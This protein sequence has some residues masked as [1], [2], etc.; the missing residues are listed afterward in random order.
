MARGDL[1]VLPVESCIDILNAL[2]SPASRFLSAR[3]VKTILNVRTGIQG[4]DELD[5]FSKAAEAMIDTLYAKPQGI[6]PEIWRTFFNTRRVIMTCNRDSFASILQTVRSL[7]STVQVLALQQSY[8]DLMCNRITSEQSSQ[9]AAA[10][11]ASQTAR[12]GDLLC[13]GGL[14]DLDLGLARITSDDADELL[15]ALKLLQKAELRVDLAHGSPW[16]PRP[17][18]SLKSF[19]VNLGCVTPGAA[20]PAAPAAPAANPV[21]D[22]GPLCDAAHSLGSISL[23]SNCSATIINAHQLAQLKSLRSLTCTYARL[24]EGAWQLLQSLPQLEYAEVR[25]MDVSITRDS[26]ML[27]RLATLKANITSVAVSAGMAAQGGLAR[28]LPSLQRLELDDLP[29]DVLEALHGSDVQ[30]LKC[31]ISAEQVA[32][33][34]EQ[35]LPEALPELRSIDCILDVNDAADALLAAAAG[36][37]HLE[38]LSVEEGARSEAYFGFEA[39]ELL[40]SGRCKKLR[41]AVLSG[42][43]ASLSG[44]MLLTTSSKQVL[45]ELRCVDVTARVLDGEDRRWFRLESMAAQQREMQQ[46]AEQG[47]AR[48]CGKRPM[49]VYDEFVAAVDSY[50][51]CNALLAAFLEGQEPEELFCAERQTEGECPG[52]MMSWMHLGLERQLGLIAGS[53]MHEQVVAVV[54]VCAGIRSFGGSM[55]ECQV[56]LQV[57]TSD[58]C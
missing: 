21:L 10:I 24:Q 52:Q 50:V 17:P 45:P 25:E 54:D 5:S 7:P 27:R 6:P 3:D 32:A 28:L 19:N 36:C 22:L 31:H 43:A 42:Y 55:G 9:L 13:K 53:V 51:A 57:M 30:H 38:E 56:W 35:R 4:A 47:S 8:A 37:E 40:A 41:R 26:C 46:E 39:F 33:A 16:S 20:A 49:V 23:T 18:A 2:V 1:P 29:A 15:G 34:L 11:V 44:L 14:L 58:F 12:P 48:E